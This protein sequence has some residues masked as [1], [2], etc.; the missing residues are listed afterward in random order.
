MCIVVKTLVI[1]KQRKRECE[2]E[3]VHRGL[4]NHRQAIMNIRHTHKRAHLGKSQSEKEE[5][6]RC[7]LT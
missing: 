2:Q 3:S 1:H 6:H 7:K 4:N 5:E